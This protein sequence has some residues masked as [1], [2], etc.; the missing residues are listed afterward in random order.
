[1]FQ[2]AH[3]CLKTL[4]STTK[5]TTGF[6]QSIHNNTMSEPQQAS[7]S[8]GDRVLLRGSSWIGKVVGD[9]FVATTPDGANVDA[10]RI[11]WDGSRH[12]H[13][14]PVSDLQHMP[15]RGE[16][17]RKEGKTAHVPAFQNVRSG[18][19]VRKHPNDVF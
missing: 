11:R 10:V 7:M 16:R 4:I 12:T 18:G 8:N 15:K 14:Y 17:N 19:S 5:T 2:F 9:T 6:L 3:Q 1:M 13:K